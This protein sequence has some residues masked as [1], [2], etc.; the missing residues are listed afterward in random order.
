MF[1]N[2]KIYLVFNYGKTSQSFLS[3]FI[4]PSLCIDCCFFKIS[5]YCF[6][7]I[8]FLLLILEK[9][10]LNVNHLHFWRPYRTFCISAVVRGERKRIITDAKRFE[11][12]SAFLAYNAIFFKY[13][14]DSR[15]TVLII[16]LW[17]KKLQWNSRTFLASLAEPN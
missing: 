13:S 3:W 4:L 8:G 5:S 10:V 16:L 11:L 9:L 6:L 7:K 17:W 14:L 2:F 15:L 1:E 12:Y